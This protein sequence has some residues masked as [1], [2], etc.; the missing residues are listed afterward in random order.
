[1]CSIQITIESDE[2][3]FP[4]Y[5]SKYVKFIVKIGLNFVAGQLMNLVRFCEL[6]VSKCRNL[7]FISVT[8]TVNPATH[9]NDQQ[10]AFDALKRDLRSRN[11]TINF[12]FADGLHDRQI[13]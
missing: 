12:E 5:L 4:R 7:K 9:N 2:L 6:V 13:M 3:F 1:M 8:T 10:T 11:I